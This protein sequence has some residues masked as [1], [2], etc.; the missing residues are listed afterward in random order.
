M[1]DARNLRRW[2]CVLA[3]A[4]VALVAYIV[5]A[6]VL[7]LSVGVL[8]ARDVVPLS[9]SGAADIASI[10]AGLFLGILFGC[11]CWRRKTRSGG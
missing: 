11:Q 4:G 8:V 7:G 9:F 5:L 2:P 1:A 10:V 3:G 6:V